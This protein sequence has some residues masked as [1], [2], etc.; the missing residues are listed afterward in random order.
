M[1]RAQELI[2]SG[3]QPVLYTVSDE[4]IAGALLDAS[5]SFENGAEGSD[6]YTAPDP[7][8][9]RALYFPLP[10]C[11]SCGVKYI[12]L[13]KHSG[14]NYC[15]SP[16]H[17]GKRIALSEWQH[18]RVELVSSSYEDGGL[19]SG[20]IGKVIDVKSTHLPS[21]QIQ[22]DLR[23]EWESGAKTCWIGAEDFTE[24]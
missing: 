22:V 8:S 20:D 2:A 5:R 11:P 4:W 13:K 15:S 17:H 14:K 24:A 18:E 6:V 9:K 10:Y 21:G 19:R 16:N 3:K 7:N 12:G 1:S 23:V